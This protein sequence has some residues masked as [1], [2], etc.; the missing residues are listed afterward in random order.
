MAWTTK[1]SVFTRLSDLYCQ[2][3]VLLADVENEPETARDRV[4][5]MEELLDS[6][7]E[8]GLESEYVGIVE[9]MIS[10]LAIIAT[11]EYQRQYCGESKNKNP[12]KVKTNN[13]GNV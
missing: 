2:W 5:Q 6:A 8:V 13:G 1:D 4:F 10:D 3:P 9:D 12:K 11:K 7:K